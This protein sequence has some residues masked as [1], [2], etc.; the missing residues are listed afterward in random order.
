MCRSLIFGRFDAI[1]D[2]IS[3]EWCKEV[4]RMKHYISSEN[5]EKEIK[6]ILCV[7]EKEKCVSINGVE[8]SER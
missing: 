7:P 4:L 2:K 6:D 5:C 3:K 1:D 8:Y